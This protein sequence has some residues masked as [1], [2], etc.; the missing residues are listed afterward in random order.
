M[1]E[2]M[3]R[4]NEESIKI[5]EVEAG[6]NA[7]QLVV[8]VNSSPHGGG[9]NWRFKKLNLPTFNRDKPDGRILSANKFFNFYRRSVE[10]KL[11]AAVVAFEDDSLAWYQWEQ[12]R[13]PITQWVEMK[14]MILG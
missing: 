11:E 5:M 1:M 4:S 7:D 13:H 14:A 3:K 9:S 10:D 6:S 8:M 12:G 2:Q